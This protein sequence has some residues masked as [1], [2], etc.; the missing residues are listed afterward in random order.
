MY[1]SILKIE[2]GANV[3]VWEKQAEEF[4]KQCISAP[5]PKI[6]VKIRNEVNIFFIIP[7]PSPFFK[8][9]IFFKKNQG[10]IIFFLIL[11]QLI[12]IVYLLS[13]KILFSNNSFFIK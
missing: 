2:E 12:K 9:T 11:T 5:L 6:K 8:H 7:K 4:S 3:F 13:A 10:F 1:G